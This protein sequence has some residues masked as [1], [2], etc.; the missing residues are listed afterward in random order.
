MSAFESGAREPVLVR[1]HA[2]RTNVGFLQNLAVLG[3]FFLAASAC[4]SL[5]CQSARAQAFTWDPSGTLTVGSMGGSGTWN[6]TINQWYT[7][8]GTTLWSPGANAWFGG[9][10][11]GTVTLAGPETVG[12]MTFNTS[13]YTLTGGTLTVS[14]AVTPGTIAANQNVT[15]NSSLADNGGG[16]T[17]AGG[18]LVT[19]DAT[20]DNGVSGPVTVSS[21]TL[22][23]NAAVNTGLPQGFCN[24]S[25]VTIDGGASL[26]VNTSNAL[27]GYPTQG[28]VIYIYQGGLLAS[29]NTTTTHLNQVEMDG[30]T[31]SAAAVNADGSWALDGGVLTPGNGDDRTSYILG[32]NLCLSQSTGGGSPSGTS[33]NVGGGDTLY[34]GAQ[35]TLCTGLASSTQFSLVDQGSGTLVL[36]GSNT[37]TA[38]TQVSNGTL[39][40]ANTAALAASPLVISGGAVTFSGTQT[41]PLV[42]L[43]GNGGSLVLNN[44]SGTAVN[45]SVGSNG[46]STTYGGALTGSGSLT[47]TGGNLTLAGN[48]SNSPNATNLNGGV[49]TLGSANAMGTGAITFSGGTLQYTSAASGITDLSPHFNATA[50]NQFYIDTG[51]QNVTYAGSLKSSGGLLDKFGSGLLYLGAASN[52]YGP[53]TIDGGLLQFAS[54]SSLPTGQKVFIHAGGALVASGYANT[55]NGW[56]TAGKIDGSANGAIALTPSSTDTDVNFSSY[57]SLSLGAMGAVTY[58][59]TIEPGGNGYFL[60]GGGGTSLG[61]TLTVITRLTGANNLTVGNGGGGTVVLANSGDNWTGTTNIVA[62]AILQSGDGATLLVTPTGAITNNGTLV[63]PNAPS[64]PQTF[65]SQISGSGALYAFGSSVLTLNGANSTG[66][67]YANGGTV[68]VNGSFSTTGKTVFGT[69]LP[70]APQAPAVVNWNATGAFTGGGFFGVADTGQTATLNVNG[71]NLAVGNLT[72]F[73]GNGTSGSAA[74]G[75]LNLNAGTVSITSASGVD[76]GGINTNASTSTGVVNINSGLLSIP[77]GGTVATPG[78]NNAITMTFA[79]NSTAAVYLNGG[80]LATGRSFVL[81]SGASSSGTLDLNGGTLQGT[82][83]NA[84]WFQGVTVV[85]DT[86]GAIIDTQ[87]YTMTVSSINT[88]IGPGSLTK[89]GSGQLTLSGDN[90]YIGGTVI[91]NGLVAAQSETSL[92]P[93]PASFM[94][95]NITL[96]GGELRD[97]SNGGSLYLSANRGILLGPAGGVL[98]AGW[99]NTT[100]IAGVIANSTSGGGGLT[101]PNDG[102]GYPGNNVYL[103]NTAN[104]YTGSTTIGGGALPSDYNYQNISTLNVAYLTNGGQNSSIGASSSAASNLVFKALNTSF[105]ASGGTGVLNYAGSG[106]STNRLFTIASGAVAQINNI[107]TGSLNFTNSGAIQFTGNTQ[108]ATLALGGNYGSSTNTFAPAITDAAVPTS[109]AVNGSLWSLTGSNNTFSG[110]TVLN[111]GTLFINN[112]IGLP[113]SVVT[114]NGGNLIF[115][116]GVTS[117]AVAGLSGTGSGIALQDANANPITLYVGANGASS[118]YYGS[119]SG[120][121]NLVKAGAGMLTL[122]AAQSYG[123]TTVVSGGTLQIAPPVLLSGFGGNGTGWV[124]NTSGTGNPANV[125]GNVLTLTTSAVGSCAASLWYGAPVSV[126]NSRW[127]A[128]WTFNNQFGSGADGGAFVLQSAGLSAIGADGGGKGFQGLTTSAGMVW[129]IYN[130][131]TTS[132]NTAGNATCAYGTT[133]SGVNLDTAN[134]PVT[135][136]LSYDGLG[137]VTATLKQGSNTFTMPAYSGNLESLLGNPAGGLAYLGFT[138]GD[139]ASKATQLVSNFTFTALPGLQ[140]VN[141]LPATTALQLNGVFDLEGGTQALAS[142]SGSGTVT[143]N[144]AAA[145]ALLTPGSDGSNQTFSGA[146]TGNLALAKVGAGALTLGGSSNYTGGTSIDGG[147]IVAAQRSSLGSGPVDLGSGTLDASA[148]GLA[149]GTLT[150]SDSGPSALDV[151]LAHPLTIGGAVKLV[152]GGTLNVS[153]IHY[154]NPQLVMT[155]S[156]SES[157]TFDSALYN[158]SSVGLSYSGGSI[159]VTSGTTVFSG[160]GYWQGS[161][162]PWN[163]SGNWTDG[164]GHN[165]VPGDGSRPAGTDAAYF[166]GSGATTVNLNPT[167]PTLSALSFSRSNYTLSSGSLTLYNSSGAATITVL[168]GTST[169]NATAALSLASS[170]TVA[171]SAGAQL[172]IGGPLAGSNPL[173]LDGPGALVLSDSSQFDGGLIVENGTL[174]AT[175]AAALADGSSLIV[176]TASAFATIVPSLSA[177]AEEAVPVSNAAVAPVPEP[178]ALALLAAALFGGAAVYRRKYAFR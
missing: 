111:G 167:N 64:L 130:T 83:T 32:G 1:S 5:A 121:G 8:G 128:S 166:S 106:D 33:F 22:L 28:H 100:T 91:N 170:T 79:D 122:G 147:T 117:P 154:T 134:S 27:F 141:V 61:G 129:E 31:L 135:F 40:L 65:T 156:G 18:H 92:G 7:S 57:P 151:S 45:V 15:I 4:L 168:S 155:Y 165:G 144:F 13:G 9:S 70:G 107:G 66:V 30:G 153:G 118:T 148:N 43:S 26:V 74:T 76:I 11:G 163:V 132:F 96:N 146:I 35:I 116:Y 174:I 60:G 58:G 19:L 93:V 85:A 150:V 158:G 112:N 113:N 172:T 6:D 68:D 46:V 10:A 78:G 44:T 25:S 127:T 159:D 119:L 137:T 97:A 3:V 101:I 69:N 131:S 51:G 175:N 123:G 23:L 125:T 62:G 102:E 94:S 173:T 177:P 89:L 178:G 110:G 72:V 157:G 160:S 86:R 143:N 59:G 124:L 145:T 133:V 34:V 149:I 24:A 77:S 71:G 104:T 52:S 109:L 87:G 41:F 2:R 142:L 29:P 162:S 171:P 21:G 136:T 84:N 20:Y 56:L 88:V 55:V 103:A 50:A 48:N 98:R 53:T 164:Y 169:L 67:F 75:T 126:A 90:N 49:L 80:V 138:G 161:S 120:P 42:S 16:V 105:A 95:N 140:S 108:A 99:S 176:G 38:S 47:L 36:A 17:F 14:P 81:G 152:S 114:S 54:K 37:F 39:V 115:A 82:A 63:L 12:N 73:I 139:G